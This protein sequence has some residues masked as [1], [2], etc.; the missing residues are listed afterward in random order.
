M[1]QALSAALASRARRGPVL[2]A[3]GHEH[4]LQVLKGDV[5]DYMLVSGAGSRTE[6]TAVTSGPDTLFAHQQT[7]FMAL[8]VGSS[9]IRVSVV[10]PTPGGGTEVPFVVDV[11]LQAGAARR[12]SL[13]RRSSFSP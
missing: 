11:P 1:R 5:V 13:R 2:Y 3:S 4:S 7:G 6:I 10:E 12:T 9:A 8:D